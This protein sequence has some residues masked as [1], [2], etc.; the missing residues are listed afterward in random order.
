M[1]ATAA[2]IVHASLELP[3]VVIDSYNVE[4]R[5]KDG[6][7]GDRASNRAFRAILDD[8]R[9]RLERHAG[10]DPLG[11]VPSREISK[12]KLDKLLV[13]GDPEAAGLVQSAIED[14]A[15]ELAAVVRRFL[16]L[17]GW[18]DTERIV[19]GGGFRESRMGELAIGRASV[20]LKG[21]GI[22]ITL[23]AIRNHPDEA[24]LIG[25]CHLAPAWIFKGHDGILAIDIGGSNMRAG[26]VRPN[27]KK[28]ADASK[29]EVWKAALWRYG[30]DDPPPSR[31]GAV[32]RLTDMLEELIVEAEK[33]G[34][35]LAPFIGVGCPGLINEEGSIDRGGQNLPGNWESSRFNLPERL[36]KAIPEIDDHETMVVMHNDAVVQG[37]SEA[38][39]MQDVERWGVLTIGT[40]L[41]NARFTNRDAGS[42]RK[43]AQ[44]GKAT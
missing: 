6:F 44:N 30:D 2:D 32:E 40:G 38:P 25:A 13:E 39:F 23:A 15:Q 28:E 31:D 19:V 18:R 21:E 27:L 22:D 26:I 16:R 37:L 24:G 43:K 20:L 7:I 5:D 11:D 29:A 4:L 34:L 9:E 36:R 1:V 42:R 12:K 14:F 8:W 41:G 3:S 35:S 17:K 33:K 10:E